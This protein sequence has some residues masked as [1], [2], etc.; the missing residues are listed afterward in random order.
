MRG[1]QVSGERAEL[2]VQS[3]LGRI[4]ILDIPQPVLAVPG[5]GQEPFCQSLL[6]R[7]IQR[8]GIADNVLTVTLPLLLRLV[9]IAR[10]VEKDALP[11]SAVQINYGN[12]PGG[13]RSGTE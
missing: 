13:T 4:P 8:H 10:C 7:S 11:I 3:F 1:Q 5:E 12:H 2:L 6:N 9:P